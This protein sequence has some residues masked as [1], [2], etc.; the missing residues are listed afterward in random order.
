M[1]DPR[2]DEA[3]LVE[4]DQA[5]FSSNLLLISSK[6]SFSIYDVP[7][8]QSMTYLGGPISDSLSVILSR[9]R[10]LR[11]KQASSRKGNTQGFSGGTISSTVCGRM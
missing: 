8:L 4:T 5:S 10:V 1:S 2:G 3:L 11:M 6:R 9:V 7:V